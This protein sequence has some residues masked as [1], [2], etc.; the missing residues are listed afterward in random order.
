MFDANWWVGKNSIFG[1]ALQTIGGSG[2]SFSTPW[3]TVGSSGTVTKTTH[4]KTMTWA[5][6]G[7]LLLLAWRK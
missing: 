1:K 2:A 6:V 5:V 3:G 7:A 4:D